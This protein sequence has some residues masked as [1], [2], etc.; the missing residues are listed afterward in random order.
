[1]ISIEKNNYVQPT[2]VRDEVVQGI[3]EA[4]L[5][6]RAWTTFHPVSDGCYRRQTKYITKH[7]GGKKYE[8]F[9][10]KPFDHEEGVQFNGA[11]MRKAF[12]VLQENGYYMFRVYE[13]RTWMGYRCSRKPFLEG[14]T[15]V[16]EFT[17]FID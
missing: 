15:R 13:Y 5:D 16:T 2:Q 17:D 12:Q 6:G 3:C 8:S 7:K 1:M 11:E 10:D 9:M 4:F 14:G